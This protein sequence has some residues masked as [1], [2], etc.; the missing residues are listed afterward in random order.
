MV[1]KL[2]SCL[3]VIAMSVSCSGC[4]I[5]APKMQNVSVSTSEPDAEIFVNGNLMGTGVATARVRRNEDVAIL[6]K[7]DGFYPA[8]RTIEPTLSTTGILDII[9]GS[10]IL[11]PFFGLMAAGAHKLDTSNV[12]LVM[13]R[14]KKSPQ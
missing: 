10:I 9:G 5:F 7:K 1:N 14:E 12:V 13:S 2:I 6:A 3:L 11:L 4:S 8:V